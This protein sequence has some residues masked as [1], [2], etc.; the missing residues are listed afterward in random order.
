MSET[1]LGG[2]HS[3]NICVG[4]MGAIG[5]LWKREAGYLHSFIVGNFNLCCVGCLF[6][7][8]VG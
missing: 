5:C 2:G 3:C 4:G 8:F 1:D 6:L 7:S